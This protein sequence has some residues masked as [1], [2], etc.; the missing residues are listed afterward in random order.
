MESSPARRQKPG[1]NN[2]SH[3]SPPN[4]FSL[5]SLQ[6]KRKSERKIEVWRE[7]AFRSRSFSEQRDLPVSVHCWD[8]TT[9]DSSLL[10]VPSSLTGWVLFMEP[11]GKL[12]AAPE[13]TWSPFPD[14]SQAGSLRKPGCRPYFMG[15]Q[16]VFYQCTF[17]RRNYGGLLL[18]LI[19]P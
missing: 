2:H 7:R 12:K 1:M 8:Y 10:L 19:H 17:K 3:S 18:F 5:W 14:R 9:Q 11:K 6:R 13:T 16:H 15:L 4:P